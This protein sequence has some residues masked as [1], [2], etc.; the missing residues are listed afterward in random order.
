M[1]VLR[2]TNKKSMSKLVIA[3][4]GITSIVVIGAGGILMNPILLGAGVGGLI[5]C[6]GVTVSTRRP[7][8][9]GLT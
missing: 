5:L 8:A 2:V 3:I 6:C 9:L 4:L 7:Q 1:R